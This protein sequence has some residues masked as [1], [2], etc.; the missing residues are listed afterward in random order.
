VEWLKPHFI[1]VR[2]D[3]YCAVEERQ[4]RGSGGVRAV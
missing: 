2:V 3:R 1:P 4:R